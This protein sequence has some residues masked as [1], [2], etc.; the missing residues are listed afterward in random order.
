MSIQIIRKRTLSTDTM[1]MLASKENNNYF[2]ICVLN[3]F[4]LICIPGTYVLIVTDHKPVIP[5]LTIKNVYTL[6]PRIQ[7]LILKAMNYQQ[8]MIWRR[9][10]RKPFWLTSVLKTMSGSELYFAKVT[11]WIITSFIAL[12]IFSWPH[13]ISILNQ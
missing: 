12:D 11:I 3:T 7:K 8:R 10:A 9:V 4:N 2:A 6:S 13:P 1:I 5:I